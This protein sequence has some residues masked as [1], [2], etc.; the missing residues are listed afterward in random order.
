MFLILTECR[1]KETIHIHL[2]CHKVFNEIKK[3]AGSKL[4][5]L[6]A[7]YQRVLMQV[8]FSYL[9]QAGKTNQTEM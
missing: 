7:S 4:E 5:R 8:H 1:N 2:S 6:A 3:I 9:D